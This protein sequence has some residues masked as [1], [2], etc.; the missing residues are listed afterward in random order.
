MLERWRLHDIHHRVRDEVQ[1]IHSLASRY[2]SESRNPAARA[3]FEAIGQR[4]L[5]V[6]ALH[7]HLL[8]VGMCSGLHLSA[9]WL[10]LIG[11]IRLTL[12]EII[13]GV[14]LTLRDPRL[15]LRATGLQSSA[16]AHAGWD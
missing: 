5:S 14:W 10:A 9:V 3:E 4:A 13:A 6:A 2:A 15:R 7:D 16:P 8:G 12:G 11:L 1:Q